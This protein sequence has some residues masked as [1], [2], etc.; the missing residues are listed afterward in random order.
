ME[1]NKENDPQEGKM[2]KAI[3]R[4]RQRRFKRGE[5]EPAEDEDSR[6]KEHE[7]TARGCP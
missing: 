2:T 6:T 3:L 7:V 5:S 1:E 4:N